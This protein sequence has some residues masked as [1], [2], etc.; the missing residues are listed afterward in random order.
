MPWT[1]LAVVFGS[2]LLLLILTLL[3]YFWKGHSEDSR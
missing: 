2:W 1:T 3:S